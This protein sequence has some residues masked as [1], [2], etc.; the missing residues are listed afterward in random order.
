MDKISIKEIKFDDMAVISH[1]RKPVKP[2][3]AIIAYEE[4]IRGI[5]THFKLLNIRNNTIFYMELSFR[6]IY[7]MGNN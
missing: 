6:Y 4:E 1:F 3:I 5:N 7:I 2:I